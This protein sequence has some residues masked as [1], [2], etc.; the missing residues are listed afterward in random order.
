MIRINLL[1]DRHAKD[2]RIIQQQIQLAMFVAFVVCVVCGAWYL[3]KNG[4]ISDIEASIVSA[5]AEKKKLEDIKK[6]VED[7][8]KRQKQVQA[9]L[10][11]IEE[12]NEHKAGPTPYMDDINSILPKEV[13]LTDIVDKMGSIRLVGFSYSPQAVAELMTK[14]SNST[15]FASVD[16]KGT[17]SVSITTKSGNKS[18]SRD[19][20][21]F[22]I[23]FMTKLAQKREDEMAKAEE[24]SKKKKGAK[25]AKAPAPA[26]GKHGE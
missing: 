20:Q 16:L 3:K 25:G 19:V 22:T 6:R 17:E 7:M 4:D 18:F 15:F 26:A 11:T 12:L 2:R 8:E 10:K 1:A 9:I 5:Q 21:K 23:T 13:W 14:L 24:A